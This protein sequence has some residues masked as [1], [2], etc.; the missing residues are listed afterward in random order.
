[1]DKLKS[2]RF[3]LYSDALK[4][5][6]QGKNTQESYEFLTENSN[7]ILLAVKNYLQILKCEKKVNTFSQK[8]L[9]TRPLKDICKIHLLCRPPNGS[10]FV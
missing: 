4:L 5:K 6:K 7:F 8:N 1:M 10:N 9:L 3:K 2:Y